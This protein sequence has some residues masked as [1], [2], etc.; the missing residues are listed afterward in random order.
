MAAKAI[1]VEDGEGFLGGDRRLRVRGGGRARQEEGSGS[2]KESE[3]EQRR[4]VKSSGDPLE[5]VVHVV[6]IPL[7]NGKL[8]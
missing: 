1:L 8:W 3:A 5:Q 6:F 2:G 7:F 4:P